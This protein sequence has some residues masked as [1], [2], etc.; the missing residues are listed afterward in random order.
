MKRCPGIS[1]GAALFT[2]VFRFR[3]RDAAASLGGVHAVLE[4]QVPHPG[5]ID[6]EAAEVDVPGDLADR[7][8]QIVFPLP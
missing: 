1:S 5:L 3:I 4:V 7:I 8:V 6:D 2:T